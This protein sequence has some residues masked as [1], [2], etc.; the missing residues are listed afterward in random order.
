MDSFG[1]FQEMAAG[2]GQNIGGSMA[3]FNEA[4]RVLVENTEQ[5]DDLIRKLRAEVEFQPDSV[6][7]TT[8]TYLPRCRDWLTTPD[9]VPGGAPDMQKF[10]VQLE[11]LQ[12]EAHDR[13]D[14]KYNKAQRSPIDLTE[15]QLRSGAPSV[16][17]MS[18]D[19]DETPEVR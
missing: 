14:G 8:E 4:F 16:Q 13:K 7:K 18:G 3:L 19:S 12:Q 2:M 10:I 5:Q 11:A 9:V 1:S 6:I 17:G 15:T